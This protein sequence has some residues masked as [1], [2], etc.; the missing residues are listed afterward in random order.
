MSEDF[1]RGGRRVYRWIREPASAAPPPL[2][3]VGGALRGGPGAEL[4]AAAAAWLPVWLRPDVPQVG[5][6]EW[7]RPLGQLPPFPPLRV[8]SPAAAQA[9]INQLPLGRASGLDDWVGEEL[10]L[11]PP[12]LVEAL[13]ALLVR[14]EDLGRW[15]SGLQGAE[16]VLLPKPVGDLSDPMGRRPLNMLSVVYRLWARLRRV[17]VAAWRA[18]WDPAVAAATLGAA[19]QAW[20]L[21]WA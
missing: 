3:P 9:G 18:L 12:V 16:V 1:Q 13:T 21:A 10:R 7:L 11:W 2:V 4:D 6:A 8:L 20:E 15:P 17:E 14:V 19:G 5:E